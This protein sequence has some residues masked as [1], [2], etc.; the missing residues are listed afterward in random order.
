MLI[1]LGLLGYNVSIGSTS[2]RHKDLEGLLFVET[3][4]NSVVNDET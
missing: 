4:L 1:R 3:S 2:T